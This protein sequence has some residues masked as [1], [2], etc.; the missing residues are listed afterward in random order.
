MHE[1]RIFSMVRKTKTCFRPNLDLE[2]TLGSLI[3]G[4]LATEK[5]PI[6]KIKL[7]QEVL[8]KAKKATKESNKSF[9]E[10]TYVL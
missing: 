8:D 9:I 2:E 6:H 7:P 4:K 10:G 3:T 1:E 5:E